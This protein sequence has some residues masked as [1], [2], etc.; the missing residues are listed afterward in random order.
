MSIGI[1][2]VQLQQKTSAGGG[3]LTGAE[4]G[5]LLAGTVVR[6]GGTLIN[7]TGIDIA[8]NALQI[9]DN[10]R[11]QTLI[12]LDPGA[13]LYNFG[14]E[15]IGTGVR[16]LWSFEQDTAILY[17][18]SLSEAMRIE[19][20]SKTYAIGDLQNTGGGLIALLDNT[21]LSYSLRDAGPANRYFSI[22]VAGAQYRIGDIDGQNN[23][24]FFEIEDSSSLFRMYTGGVDYFQIDPVGG[25]YFI[26]DVNQVHN[27]AYIRIDD[28]ANTFRI[29]NTAQNM[30]IEINGVAGATG[31]FNVGANVITVNGG[32]VTSIV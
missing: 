29:E 13:N 2:N 9:W 17:A 3:S 4:N 15:D 20:S 31:V 18:G 8:N 27:G 28:T 21:S 19:Q 22:D 26:G 6:L 24:S 1:G 30:N 7:P 25:N 10:V 16:N 12:W 14:I 5:L 23:N 32:I 11:N